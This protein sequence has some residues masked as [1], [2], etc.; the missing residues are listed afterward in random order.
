MKAP[1][2]AQAR[3]SMALL[4]KSLSSNVNGFGKRLTGFDF[5]GSD[6]SVLPKRGEDLI[7]R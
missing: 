3:D 2:A 7:D 1:V 5:L 4:P 6:E